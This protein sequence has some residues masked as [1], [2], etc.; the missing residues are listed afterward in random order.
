MKFLK[1]VTILYSDDIPRSLDYYTR[2]LGFTEQWAWD[3][4]PTFGGVVRDDVE[5]FFCK[6]D[7][8]NPGTW[9]SLMVD[10][11]DEYY[12]T[13][14]DKGAEIISLPDTKPW[15]MREM[16][17]RDPDRHIIRIGHNTACD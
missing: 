11:V 17:V 15:G 14:K 3:D 10:N 2:I 6:G 9:F 12:K 16:L 13:I 5:V 4:P 7:Q 8:G 1:S